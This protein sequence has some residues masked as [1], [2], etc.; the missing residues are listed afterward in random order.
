MKKLSVHR[1]LKL[2]LETE[3]VLLLLLWESISFHVETVAI[4]CFYDLYLVAIKGFFI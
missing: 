2:A 4:L 1:C 3:H